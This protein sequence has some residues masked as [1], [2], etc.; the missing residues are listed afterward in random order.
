MNCRFWF[1]MYNYRGNDPDGCAVY[2]H[3]EDPKKL[4]QTVYQESI[5]EG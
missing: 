2:H 1:R 5:R 3:P 4:V